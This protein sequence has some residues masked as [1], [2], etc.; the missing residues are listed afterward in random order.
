M[1]GE[2]IV[3]YLFSGILLAAGVLSMTVQ[4]VAYAALALLAA[5]LGVAALYLALGAD[6]MGV[7]QIIVYVGGILV[8]LVFGILLTSRSAQ[9]TTKVGGKTMLFAALAASAL[10]LVM[11][12][13]VL[14]SEW[15]IVEEA[16]PE[17]S[18]GRIGELF[19]GRYLMPFELASIV[20]LVAL[21]GAAYIARRGEAK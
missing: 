19:L 4:R 10:L 6:F 16:R 2:A 8:L 7:T 15:T 1:D 13:A 21:I 3:F 5:L 14:G 9:E 18:V 12:S 17:A 20:L 11:L